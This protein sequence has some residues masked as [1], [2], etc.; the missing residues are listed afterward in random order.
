M[1]EDAKKALRREAAERR[2]GVA[3]AAG[4]G[5][6][7]ALAE[8]FLAAVPLPPP[9]AAVS[10]FWSMGAE[11]DV[12]PLLMRLDGFGY[13]C[14]LPVTVKRG[15]PLVFRR[16]TLATALI[17]GGFGTSIPP[18]EAEAIVPDLLI[19]PLLAFDRQGWRLGYGGGFYDRTL[20]EL[21]RHGT[22]LAVGVGYAGQEVAAVPHAD[23]DQ[24]LDWMVTERAAFQI[25]DA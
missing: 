15:L 7:A 12:R 1:I 6:G 3:R 22:P 19:V 16:W 11:I 23:Y 5:A 21:R 20:A 4:P 9:G 17:D 2:L 13:R 14:C 24:R 25:G 10:G 18:Q 8:R